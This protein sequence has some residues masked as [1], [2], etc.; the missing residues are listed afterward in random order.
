MTFFHA[1]VKLINMP[2]NKDRNSIK[3]CVCWKTTLHESCRKN[4]QVRVF[5]ARRYA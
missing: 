4:L 1:T 5:T 2:F 3:N